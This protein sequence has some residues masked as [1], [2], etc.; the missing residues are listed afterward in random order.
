MKE[1]RWDKNSDASKFSLYRKYKDKFTDLNH[2]ASS[3][4]VNYFINKIKRIGEV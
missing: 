4:A 1:S 3:L 2:P